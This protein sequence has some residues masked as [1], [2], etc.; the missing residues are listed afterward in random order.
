M[1]S[2]KNLSKFYDHFKAVDNLSFDIAPGNIVGFLGP[3]GA[4]KSTT[5]KMLTGFLPPS[6]GEI[7]IKERSIDSDA[8]VI[9]RD[10]G[11]LP[12]GAPAYGDMTVWQFLHFIADVR[13]L[14]GAHRKERLYD[15]IHRVE[16][17]DVLNRPIDNLSKGFKRRVGLAQAILHDPDI[18]I[19]DEPTDGLDPN[20]KH[21]VR[22]LIEELSR[23]KIVI[24]STHILEE[25]A[26]VCNRVM[27]IAD[28]QLRFDDTPE[29]LRHRSRYC[30]AVSLRLSYAA[31]ISGLAELDG[32]DEM[33]I[34]RKTG[35]VT[36]FPE[37]GKHIFHAINEYVTQRRLPVDTLTLET[38]RLDEVFRD[39][40]TAEAANG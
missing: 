23:E 33:E 21:H 15:V 20:Q 2:V 40:T 25:V 30:N 12:E 32:V 37:P 26:A 22:Q 17:G 4:G 8:K 5:M 38:G 3:N 31:D 10:I 18:L 6:E 35:V 29:V 28:G 19:L 11:Y 16:L 39:I 13:R 14:K 7:F 34:D 27:I 1:I 24:I 9:Q 36:L